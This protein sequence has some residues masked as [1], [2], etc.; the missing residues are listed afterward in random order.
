[1]N[2]RTQV[3][4]LSKK[5]AIFQTTYRIKSAYF[6]SFP[7]KH[8]TCSIYFD[9]CVDFLGEPQAREEADGSRDEEDDDAQDPHVSK[10]QQVRHPHVRLEA[11]EVDGAVQEHVNG[12]GPR[13]HKRPPPPVVVLRAELEVAH[14]H[15]DL[16]AR[17]DEDQ[18]HHQREAEHVVILVHPH[19]G[20]D[21]EELNEARAKGKD[22][23]HQHRKRRR[24]VPR[25]VWDGTGDHV[26]LLGGVL[27]GALLVSK[28]RP[29]EHERD[30]N[31]EPQRNQ[32]GEAQK[33][34]GA[35]RVVAGEHHVEEQKQHESK[36]GEEE[37]RVGGALLPLFPLERL[38][39]PRARVA[40]HRAHNHVQ[41]EHGNHQRAAVGRAQEPNRRKQNGGKAHAQELHPG[42]HHDRKHHG[43][44]LRGAEHVAVHQLP[45]ALL[46]LLVLLL[47]REHAVV[48][49]NVAVQVA[50]HDHHDH[51]GQEHHDKH[52]VDDAEPVHLIG[53]GVVH[54]EV[55]V[56]A[57]RPVDLR[58]A[59][60]HVVGEEHRPRF[61][62]H[63]LH[64]AVDAK[65]FGRGA[66]VHLV[67]LGVV[68]GG[69]VDGVFGVL[70]AAGEVG[71][72]VVGSFRVPV[73]AVGK[74]V[75]HAARL[76]VE[77]HHAV[78]VRPQ[79]V[80]LD[81]ELHVVEQVVL[82]RSLHPRHHPAARRR[83]RVAVERGGLSSG[84][85][86]PRDFV[87]HG[88]P[89]RVRGLHVP[90]LCHDGGSGEVVDDP[91]VVV[92]L[93]DGF[94]ELFHVF[95]VVLLLAQDVAVRVVAHVELVG[96]VVDAVPSHEL[97]Q[98]LR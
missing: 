52:R 88:E 8:P 56:P 43:V 20:E 16:R 13:R 11:A 64:D 79:L 91:V 95:F 75:L 38:V 66:A 28:V 6:S 17:G 68:F 21:E 48:A 84:I 36:P 44:R 74:Q 62:L 45:P 82:G 4:L 24:Q 26:G 98:V 55:D 19:G 54:G 34:D 53:H 78:R 67:P 42:A 7:T 40:A 60:G 35:R 71:H 32:G 47:F 57:A 61:Q 69:R 49:R 12:R 89:F 97:A 81:D 72:V 63:R 10:V 46:A 58:R 93:R 80:V 94:F 87:A 59:P 96:R 1:M 77:A 9:A 30:R 73:L 37:G 70:L 31:A 39:Q 25:L 3:F 85:H 27:D 90:V 18:E 23:A 2:Q 5:A 29:Q 50:H 86:A 76:H 41:H 65:R 22:A 83:G 51:N 15:R 14:H 92:L 33:G